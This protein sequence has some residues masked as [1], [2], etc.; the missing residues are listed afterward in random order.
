[1]PQKAS[2]PW[3]TRT[4]AEGGTDSPIGDLVPVPDSAQPVIDAGFIDETGK[5][6]LTAAADDSVFT[7]QDPAQALGAG[8]SLFVD[9]IDMLVHDF[10]IFGIVDTSGNNINVDMIWNSGAAVP[11]G[12]PYEASAFTDIG[13]A[14]TTW[15]SNDPGDLTG[16]MIAILSDT[17][18]DLLG[19]WKF[20][21]IG[22]LRG[23]LGQLTI[24]NNDGDAGTISTAY[25]RLV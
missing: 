13:V 1:M 25:L 6:R 7:F 2:T 22:H 12:S 8:A 3:S 21:K 5:W 24:V 15:R 9:P 20:F 16:S 17:S 4:V 23:T 10:L 19:T 18:E 14:T 11:L